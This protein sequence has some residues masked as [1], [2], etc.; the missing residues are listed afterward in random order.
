MILAADIGN[1]T[2]A[3]ALVGLETNDS[4]DINIIKIE[5]IASDTSRSSRD[6]ANQLLKLFDNVS[7][8]GA[9]IS[10]V[11]PA[12]ST[13]LAKAVHD[14]WNVESLL[15][16]KTS[17]TGLTFN[18][19]DTNTVGND[20]FVD[21]AWANAHYPLPAVTIDMGSATTFNVISKDGEF[22]GGIICA[23]LNMNLKSLHEKTAQLP[24]LTP[25]A[26][27][28]LIGINTTECMLSGAVFGQAAMIDGFLQRIE[29]KLGAP[30]TVI[31]T[32]GAAEL[33]EKYIFH[34]HI[35]DKNLLF[36]GLFLLYTMN[37]I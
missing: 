14:I 16:T 33:V 6:I 25:E 13:S 22:T 32:G 35:Y 34:P 24:L 30:V 28:S 2:I 4:K 11:V 29:K 31:I 20:R 10:S 8:E 5:K 1:T 12:L 37:S 9:I 18:K 19:V 15:V 17:K 3:L 26:P 27:S 7:L 21:A 23:G 36:K